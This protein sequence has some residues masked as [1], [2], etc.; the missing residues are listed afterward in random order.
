MFTDTVTIFHLH[1]GSWAAF[2]VHGAWLQ[3]AEGISTQSS[4]TSSGDG[5]L[6]FLPLIGD[7]ISGLTYVPPEEFTGAEDQ[8]TFRCGDF[9][10]SGAFPGAA[11]DEDY[12]DG[13]YSYMNERCGGC[14]RIVSVKRFKLIPH[15]ELGGA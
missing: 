3:S 9:F 11:S 15:F 14:F 1:E 5:A 2:V 10:V 6:L 4:G 13:Y 8:V 7:R 12:T